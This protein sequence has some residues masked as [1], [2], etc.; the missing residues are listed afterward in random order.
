MLDGNETV[1]IIR[2]STGARD[3]YGLPSV[4]ES[5][6]TIDNVLVG[7]V[8]TNEP[9]SDSENPQNVSAT[10]YFQPGTQIYPNDRF[11]IRGEIFV[12]DGRAQDWESPFAGFQAGVV[13]NVRQRVG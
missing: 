1:V 2:E 4:T 12:K 5:E 9:V 6:I 11:V 8:S 13:V 3:E 10:L 7:F